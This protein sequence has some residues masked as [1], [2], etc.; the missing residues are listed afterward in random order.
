[1][2]LC[3]MEGCDQER[4]ISIQ[5]T[6]TTRGQLGDS[7]CEVKLPFCSVDHIAAFERLYPTATE[8]MTTIARYIANFESAQMTVEQLDHATAT[9]TQPIDIHLGGRDMVII[10]REEFEELHQTRRL[11]AGTQRK[12]NGRQRD[13]AACLKQQEN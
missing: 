11:L 2:K 7:S 12:L 4:Q 5:K 1:M 9:L 8:Q 13:Y 10:P 6:I 3:F